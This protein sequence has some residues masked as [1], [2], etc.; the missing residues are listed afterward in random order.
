MQQ[1]LEKGLNQLDQ[2]ENVAPFPNIIGDEID[3]TDYMDDEISHLVKPASAYQDGMLKLIL[4]EDESQK[5]DATP[6][7]QFG[8]KFMLRKHE[9]TIWTGYKGHGK[10]AAL[11]QILVAMMRKQQRIFIVS[12]EF[13][14]ERVLERMLYQFTMTRIVDADDIRTFMAFASQHVW[15]YD[16]QSSLKPKDVIA[17]CRYA[18]KKLE[19]DHILIDSLMKCGMPTDDYTGQKNFVDQVQAIAHKYPLHLH[20][21]AHAKKGA[22]DETP[23]KLHDVKG[24]SEI[25]DMAENVVSVWRNK[26]KEKDPEKHHDEPD[27]IVVV[28]AQRNGE[29][30]IGQTNLH[31]DP[32]TIL[33]YEPGNAPERVE[34]GRF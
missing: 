32:Q 5:G 3:L 24:T 21:V 1:R 15:L 18:A 12:P 9:M 34:R 26:P 20:L 28:E 6:W 2:F 11:S 29:G 17:L 23:A 31:F 25:A 33:F 4:G 10:S 7:N 22:S 30:W 8:K 27:A 19:V 13:R 16:T 14:P